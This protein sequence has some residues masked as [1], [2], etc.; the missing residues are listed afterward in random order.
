MSNTRET[1]I[2]F[3]F[4]DF[5]SHLSHQKSTAGN[6]NKLVNA[7]I[8]RDHTK[9]SMVERHSLMSLENFL[10]IQSV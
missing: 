6:F 1:T 7:K 3:K 8:I 9:S 2:Y 5:Y 4:H 10:S